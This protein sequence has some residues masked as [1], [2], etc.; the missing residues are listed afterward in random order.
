MNQQATAQFS[1]C[2][3]ISTKEGEME[4][5]LSQQLFGNSAKL[6]IEHNDQQYYLRITRNGKLILTK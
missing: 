6:A 4:R 5:I 2:I 1:R 3:V